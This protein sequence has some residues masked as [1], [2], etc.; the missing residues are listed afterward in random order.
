M[1]ILALISVFVDSLAGH[2]VENIPRFAVDVVTNQTSFAVVLAA[3]YLF[4]RVRLYQHLF[5][6]FTGFFDHFHFQP[7]FLENASALFHQFAVGGG[8]YEEGCI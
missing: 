3:S 2:P 5:H 7:R 1:D 6:G 8:T 4:E